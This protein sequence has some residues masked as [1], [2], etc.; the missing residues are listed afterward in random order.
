[1]SDGLDIN[2]ER[3]REAAALQLEAM[4]IVAAYNPEL[5]VLH[6]PLDGPAACDCLLG[7]TSGQ[8]VGV[9]E[10]KARMDMTLQ[11]LLGSRNAEWLVTASKLT[12]LQRLAAM[13]DVPGFGFLYLVRSGLVLKVTL[14]DDA[15]TLVAPVRFEVTET[16]RTINGK[17]ATRLNAFI[18]MSGAS[19][20]WAE[21]ARKNC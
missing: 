21:P 8:L 1:M 19:R 17:R 18:S 9:A 7:N 20:Y 10:V 12:Q 13:L 2:T 5:V 11:T 4:E 3:G 14:C 6:T 16:Q 15:G